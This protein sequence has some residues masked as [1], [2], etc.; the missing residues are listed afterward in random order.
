[1]RPNTTTPPAF[2][3]LIFSNDYKR[4]RPLG[5]YIAA[6]FGWFWQ[7]PGTGTISVKADHPLAAR[8][9]QCKRDVVPIRV[10]YNG[11]NWDGRV[12]ECTIEGAPGDE[13][14]TAT[15]IGDLFWLTT[16][17]C[18]VNPLFP[19]EV[20]IGL[21]GK[22]DIM[23]GP[24]D[25]VFKWFLAR[26]AIRLGKPIHMQLPLRYDVPELPQLEDLDSL[27]DVLDAIG[28]LG[29]DLCVLNARFTRFDE[30]VRSTVDEGE[31]GLDMWLHHPDL[32][33]ESPRVFNTDTLGRLRNILDLSGDNFLH[34]TNP[35]NVL[36][37]ADPDTWGRVTEPGYVFTTRTKR[38]RT[39]MIWRTDNGSIIKYRRGVKHPTATSA[40]VGG[41]A[42]ELLN[43][44]V[45]WAANLAVKALLNWL[46]PGLGLG[47]ILVGDLFDDIFFAFQKFDDH[48]L[49]ADLGRYGFGE[50]FADN[51]A[52]WSLD[53]MSVGMTALKEHGPQ[54]SLKLEVLAGG[55]DGRGFSF[56]ADDGTGRRFRIGDV[57]SFY[58]RGTI[59]QDY[60]S[61]VEV[62]DTRGAFCTEYVTIGDDKAVRDGW[63]KVIGHLSTFAG[64][65]RAL[66]VS[67]N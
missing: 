43:N 2:D 64:L 8:L 62:E 4:A 7:T 53:A 48:Q 13:I 58:D 66:A 41:K 44:A 32:D 22:Q 39:H 50:V 52:A 59:V 33:G 9:M 18:W 5:P 34:F 67:T 24:I 60:V 35:N 45:E 54:E 21:T 49:H 47:D 30:L 42:P 10:R 37:L 25:F 15:C 61:A 56:G 20:Q 27:D 38:D 28:D 3:I 65:S 1:M 11:V 16:I 6:R 46:V 51:S 31:V 17:L 57:M 55:P 40:I 23:F 36:G 63:Q 26:N 29:D 19:P 12:L 14:V